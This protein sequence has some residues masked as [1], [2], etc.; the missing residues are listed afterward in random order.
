MTRSRVPLMRALS[1]GRVRHRESDLLNESIEITQS[2][3]STC[4]VT[5]KAE[6]GIS[7]F[8]LP[9]ECDASTAG[10]LRNMLA[11]AVGDAAVLLDLT[12]VDVLDFDGVDVLRDVIGRVHQHGGQ[13][14]VSR[15]WHL[16]ARASAL[17]GTEGL[18]FLSL[19]PA[20]G[21][22]WLVEHPLVTPTAVAQSAD[23]ASWP[24][25]GTVNRRP[26]L[27]TNL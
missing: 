13:V 14:A 18:T 27:A 25:L 15:P 22:V 26:R 16:S 23:T 21:I 9:G 8:A 4:R 3:P 19:L 12:G 17:V 24:D 11:S 20:T 10:D 5:T 7:A 1:A 2:A 6:L